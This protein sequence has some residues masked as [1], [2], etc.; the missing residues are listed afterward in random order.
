MAVRDPV[1]PQI[2][3]LK[4]LLWVTIVMGSAL[5]EG[6]AIVMMINARIA[7]PVFTK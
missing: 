7:M 1:V 6:L 2:E 4:P 5:A 3:E